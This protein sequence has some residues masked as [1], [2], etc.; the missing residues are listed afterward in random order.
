MRTHSLSEHSFICRNR[1]AIPGRFDE[2]PLRYVAELAKT[3]IDCPPMQTP[4]SFNLEAEKR[5]IQE[6]LKGHEGQ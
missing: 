6:K 3:A 4:A 2:S 1:I 5:D